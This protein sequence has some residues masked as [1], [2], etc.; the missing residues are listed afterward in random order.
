VLSFTRKAG[1]HGTLFGS[2]T[3]A[4]IA[5]ALAAQGFE[6]D[7]RKI[8]LGDAIKGLGDFKVAIRLHREVT[9]RVTVKVQAEVT[10]EEKAAAQAPVAV[11]DAEE[12][13]EPAAEETAAE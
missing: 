12:A 5:A 2:V 10:E 8:Q 13:A 9:A 11:P 3:S 1:E 6:V 4:D 7:R